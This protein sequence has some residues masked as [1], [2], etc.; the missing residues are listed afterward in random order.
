[1]YR[2]TYLEVNEDYLR[3]N[4]KNIILNYPKYKYYF[5]VVKANAYGHGE[6]IVNA[7]I[8][9]GVNYLAVSSLDEAISVR[10]YNKDIPILLFGYTSIDY[11]DEVIK[12]KITLSINS[13]D[14]LKDLLLKKVKDGLKVHIKVNTGMNRLGFNDK[15]DIKNAVE[16][17]KESNIKL[18]GIYTHYATS[19]VEDIYF[20]KQTEKFEELTSLID[21]KEIPIVH[22]CSSLPMVKHE[23]VKYTNGVRLGSVM[24]GYSASANV[25][26][27][28]K[29]AYEIRKYFKT[30]GIKTSEVILKNDLKLKKAMNLYSEVVGIN[31]IHKGEP[32]GYGAKYKPEADT[33]I[34]TISIGHADGITKYYEYVIING[35]RYQIVALCMDMLMVRVDDT[36]KVGDKVTLL[37]D[38]I[39]LAVIANNS[40]ISLHQALVSITTRVPRVHICNGEKIEIKY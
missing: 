6:H 23:K 1:M 13:F 27:I 37:G 4:V 25:E 2:K 7:I 39:S 8:D 29:T 34:A 28:K 33:F 5:G 17:L 38:G 11:I 32:V 22:T 26:G 15:E 9:G 16:L 18:E 10:K 21:L 30:G 40:G 3:D 20:D 19:G 12:N 36:V 24:Y 35:K 31:Y 14:Y